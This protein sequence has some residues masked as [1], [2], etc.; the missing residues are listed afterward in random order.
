M[1]IEKGV[2]FDLGTSLRVTAFPLPHDAT[3]NEVGK[4]STDA[5]VASSILVLFA[6]VFLTQILT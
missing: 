2:P 4:A 6:D 1:N 3:D 5:V